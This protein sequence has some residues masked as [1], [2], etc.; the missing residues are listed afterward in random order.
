[1]LA[2]E[3]EKGIIEAKRLFSLVLGED[4]YSI[5]EN[6]RMLLETVDRKIP[7]YEVTS[8]LDHLNLLRHLFGVKL[9]VEGSLSTS[10]KPKSE[11]MAEIVSSLKRE[12]L[13]YRELIKIEGKYEKGGLITS[14]LEENQ[15]IFGPK[16][17]ELAPCNVVYVDFKRGESSLR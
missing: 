4:C 11:I 14:V 9:L 8:D 7:L 16:C 1:M 6:L 10:K 17:W 15:E 2:E 5:E 12:V 13:A 3:R